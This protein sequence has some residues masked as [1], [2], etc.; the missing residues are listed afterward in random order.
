MN[1]ISVKDR[2]PEIRTPVLVAYGVRIFIAIIQSHNK[3]FTEISTWEDGFHELITHWMPL[4]EP[5]I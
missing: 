1:W 2:L 5:P 3:R 4:P